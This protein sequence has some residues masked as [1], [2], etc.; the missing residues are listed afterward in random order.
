MSAIE[1]KV[2]KVF[3]LIYGVSIFMP[4]VDIG[5]VLKLSKRK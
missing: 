5:R 1:N 2:K 3:H 4:Q